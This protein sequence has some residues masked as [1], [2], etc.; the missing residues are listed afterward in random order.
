MSDN[1]TEG[2]AF[3]STGT[4]T[5]A[6][7]STT[8]GNM[9][10]VGGFGG[11]GI[12]FAPVAAAGGVVGAATYGAFQAIGEGDATAFGALGI[13]AVGGVGFYSAVGGMGLSFG[14]TAINNLLIRLSAKVK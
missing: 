10:L 7:V 3:I 6:A 9:G 2:A 12:G 8:F 4:F 1:L 5:G 11:I 14:G 13:G